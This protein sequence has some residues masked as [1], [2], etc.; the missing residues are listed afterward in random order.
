MSIGYENKPIFAFRP[1]A[2]LSLY[3]VPLSISATLETFDK[4]QVSSV[5]CGTSLWIQNV[6]FSGSIPNAR[7]SMAAFNVLSRNLLP[8]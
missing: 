7:K 2:S 3:E 5:T 4:I 8:S 6:D 1:L